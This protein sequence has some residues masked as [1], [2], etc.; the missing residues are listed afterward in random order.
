M[1]RNPAHGWICLTQ[2]AGELD[3]SMHVY[4]NVHAI[5]GF[6]PGTGFGEHG[7]SC[8]WQIGDDTLWNVHESPSKIMA[9]IAAAIEAESPTPQKTAPVWERDP[10]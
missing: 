1:T 6:R 2:R 8:V 5:A 9:L 4:L 7:G 3:P 10:L